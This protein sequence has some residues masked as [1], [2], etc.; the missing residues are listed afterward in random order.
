MD[1]ENLSTAR[2]LWIIGQSLKHTGQSRGTKE[3]TAYW[4][5]NNNLHGL[6]VHAPQMI[7]LQSDLIIIRT[8]QILVVCGL[9][10]I[11]PLTSQLI[12]LLMTPKYPSRPEDGSG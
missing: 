5:E 10:S 12:L 1:S 2:A 11:C 3:A 6:S 7:I 8:L 9:H 4:V